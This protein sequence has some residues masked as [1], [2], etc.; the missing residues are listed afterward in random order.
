MYELPPLPYAPNELAPFLSEN[1]VKLHYEKHH[2]EY[3]K[4]LNKLTHQQ[5]SSLQLESLLLEATGELRDM[6]AQVW[7]HNFFWLSL[8]PNAEQIPTGKLA[9]QISERWGDFQSFKATFKEIA[10]KHFGSGW[11][12]LVHDKDQLEIVSTDN[13]SNP[14]LLRRKALLTV[15]VWEHSYYYDYENRRED[16]L[17]RFWNFVNWEIVA[18]RLTN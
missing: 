18:A 17:D 11:V 5:A 12:W 16:Y 4:K 2:E 1:A 14:I 9:F 13:A 10:L 15:D 8:S 6:A 7:N 3:V